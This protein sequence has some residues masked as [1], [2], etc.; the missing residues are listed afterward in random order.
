MTIVRLAKSECKVKAEVR[1]ELKL[2]PGIRLAMQVLQ[3]PLLE[4][5]GFVEK[6]LAENPLLEESI[7]ETSDDLRVDEDVDRF[8]E[9]VEGDIN[10]ETRVFD[11]QAIKFKDF[12]ESRITKPVTLAEHLLSQLK[13]QSLSESEQKIGEMIIGC[14][15]DNGYLLFSLADLAEALGENI[16]KVEKVLNIIQRFEPYGVGARNLQECLSAQL[17]LSGNN[18]SLEE[19]VVK[20][21]LLDLE[22]RRYDKI[23]RIL[24]VSISRIKQVR[25]MISHLEPKPGR[26]FGKQYTVNIIPDIILHKID[27]DY[28]IENNTEFI[29]RIR[30]NSFYKNLLK[31]HSVSGLTK[32]YLK[33]RLDSACWL[34]NAINKRRKTISRIVECIIDLQRDFFERG[35]FY[36]KPLQLKDIAGILGMHKST[37][38]RAIAGKYIQTPQG[39]FELKYFFDEGIKNDYHIHSQKCIKAM[40]EDVIDEESSLNPLS[41]NGLA[42]ILKEKGISI[43][44]RTVTKYR[45]QLKISPSYLRKE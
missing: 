11:S 37:I 7:Q 28:V 2:Y 40:I 20:N 34:V 16:N 5:K 23:S 41:D 17:R 35:T 12:L 19:L 14:L 44:R 18:N 15:D 45:E 36:L 32:D 30:I 6:E 38:S 13:M 26:R 43:S 1:P 22:K 29:P 25:D 8:I 21:H 42:N 33:E 24:G 31:N 3:L 4:L 10:A 9:Q 27:N 39:I